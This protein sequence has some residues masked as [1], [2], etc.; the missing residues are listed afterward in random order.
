MRQR[1]L[2][3]AGA[4]DTAA[5]LVRFGELFSA[6]G[7]EAL[8]EASKPPFVLLFLLVMTE[9]CCESV[10]KRIIK[11]IDMFS[12]IDQFKS[13]S[14]NKLEGM[15]DL[16]EQFHAIVKDFR[17]KKHDLLDYHNNKF[18][19]DY[20]E[21]N[22]RIGELETLMDQ[23]KNALEKMEKELRGKRKGAGLKTSMPEQ[24][25]R[26]DLCQSIAE[27]DFLEG[28][29]DPVVV[30]EALV[31]QTKKAEDQVDGLR[32][33]STDEKQVANQECE[34]DAKESAELNECTPQASNSPLWAIE[35]SHC[36]ARW[37][38]DGVWYEAQVLRHVAPNLCMVL[39]V[40]N[41]DHAVDTW[42]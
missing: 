5:R 7:L 28:D 37:N 32:V 20:V 18:D 13:L 41:G 15:E 19:R 24:G 39:F 21:F 38:E 4:C 10:R 35:G 30:E 34:N 42:L 29:K 31:E 40:G 25:A 23:Q 1:I 6:A 14:N 9:F 12:T 36:L 16:I 17:Q 33:M 3:R 11:L 22:V 27:S 2:A 8:V 26:G